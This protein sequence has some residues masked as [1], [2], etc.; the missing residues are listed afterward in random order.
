[1]GV[2]SGFATMQRP[3]TWRRFA[4][5][6]ALT[7]ALGTATGGWVARTFSQDASVPIGP[8]VIHVTSEA[9]PPGSFMYQ[10]VREV[11]ALHRLYLAG[12]VDVFQLTTAAPPPGS[13]M[14]QKEQVVRALHR[15]YLDEIAT[16]SPA[17]S[18]ES[19]IG[20]G[21]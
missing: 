21:Q 18:T 14:Y 12:K 20:G 15:L 1:M 19:V 5:V 17:R 9:P 7:F 13:F 3:G 4:A 10:K 6:V 2:Y 11:R 16:A 8:P